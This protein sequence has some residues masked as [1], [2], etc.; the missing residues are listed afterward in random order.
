MNDTTMLQLEMISFKIATSR[1]FKQTHKSCTAL[2]DHG[3]IEFENQCFSIFH[4]N[5][6][7]FLSLYETSYALNVHYCKAPS[8]YDPGNTDRFD[9][10]WIV[11]LVKIPGHQICMDM[12]LLYDHQK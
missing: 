8:L 4:S 10:S 5:I 9:L 2:S 12:V 1:H 7:S 3:H 6:D 11:E